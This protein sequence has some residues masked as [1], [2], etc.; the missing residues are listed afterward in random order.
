VAT[1]TQTSVC[2]CRGFSPCWNRTVPGSLRLRVTDAGGEPGW[3][4][5]CTGD[6]PEGCADFFDREFIIPYTGTTP[7]GE[8]HR[9]ELTESTGGPA[10]AGAGIRIGLRLATY[11]EHGAAHGCNG[12][13]MRPLCCL[14]GAAVTWCDGLYAAGVTPFPTFASINWDF[15]ASVVSPL[16][17]I[18]GEYGPSLCNCACKFHIWEG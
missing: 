11:N 16:V 17:D 14:I 6:V 2:C 18:Y 9:W 4:A 7:N 13:S 15:D 8:Y 12:G 1:Y 5:L 3:T 10:P